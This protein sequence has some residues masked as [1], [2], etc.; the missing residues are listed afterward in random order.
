MYRSFRPPGNISPDSFF[1][2]QI[3]LIS[4]AL[5]NNTC[6]LGDFNLDAR[7]SN[8]PEYHRKIPLEKLGNF[9]LNANLVQ[10]VKECTWSRTINGILK[11]SLLDHIYVNKPENVRKVSY[12]VPTLGD[13]KLVA[14]EL[15]VK[16]PLNETL[17]YKRDWSKYDPNL[18]NDK[19]LHEL[20]CLNVANTDA[21][22]VNE[23]WN[24]LENV[25]VNTIDFVAPLKAVKMSTKSHSSELPKYLKEKIT[26]RKRL[27][28]YNKTNVCTL[29]IPEIK[30]LNKEINFYFQNRRASRVKQAAL[31][32][33][34][35][36]WKAVKLAKNVC[37]SEIPQC[38]T[39]G[40][41]GVPPAIVSTIL[42][43]LYFM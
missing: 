8:V 37:H 35:N 22:T 25:L 16:A 17:L 7:M 18:I 15:V 19:M 21:L 40:G 30:L 24:V 26:K 34:V 33:K 39:L 28:H 14:I 29:R 23:F 12:F 13:H 6:L 11:E 36:I 38:M 20:S 42:G 41:V 2:S 43:I 10:L 1:D 32:P 3:S 27:L 5:T 9:A 31:G 4:K